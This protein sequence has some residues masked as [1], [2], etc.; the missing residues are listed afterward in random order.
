M[1][2]IEKHIPDLERK[3]L[4]GPLD[5]KEKF[6]YLNY[7]PHE[8]VGVSILQAFESCPISFHLRY[9]NDVEFRTNKNMDFGTIFQEALTEKYRGNDYKEWLS[10]LDEQDQKLAN[11]LIDKSNSFKDILHYDEYMFIDMG[12]GIPVR[13]AADLITKHE[14][15][16]NKTSFGYYNA[17]MAKKQMQGNLYY[18]CVKKLLGLDLPVKYQIFNKKK[19]Q[20]ELVVLKKDD[21]DTENALEWARSVLFKIKTCY[22][23]KEW[24]IPEHGKYACNLRHICPIKVKYS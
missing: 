24:I 9:Y 17:T 13:F 3:Q 7:W 19:E 14:I 1:P 2:T 22:D 23:N 15:V 6:S 12:I 11:K 16:E 5:T 21:K 8:F 18:G 4:K 20:C 10:K